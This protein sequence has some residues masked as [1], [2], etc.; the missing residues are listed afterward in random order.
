[1]KHPFTKFENYCKLALLASARIA[2]LE[3]HNIITAD[4]VSSELWWPLWKSLEDSFR[5]LIGIHEIKIDA[6]LETL[7]NK[8]LD[9]EFIHINQIEPD[10]YHFQEEI[11]TL[12]QP[13]I[14]HPSKNLDLQYL[15]KG[16]LPYLSSETKALLKTKK[17]NYSKIIDT[18]NKLNQIPIIKELW[19]INFLDTLDEMLKQL[20]LDYSQLENMQ[21]KIWTSEDL[22]ALFNS[23]EEKNLT[24]LQLYGKRNSRKIWIR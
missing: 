16:V 12:L 6:H 15:L 19:F 17:T 8:A 10:H 4:D 14:D 9:Y 11:Q 24:N 13:Y 22:N 18:T 23:L 7:E 2:K 3:N 20:N 21:I 1:M 5:A